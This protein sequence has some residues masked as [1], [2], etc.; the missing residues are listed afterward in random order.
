M[1]TGVT[2][3]IKIDEVRQEID[4]TY[5]NPGDDVEGDP[6]V[7][8]NGYSHRLIGDAFEFLCE[9]LLYR[10]CTEAVQPWQPSWGDDPKWRWTNGETPPI[11]VER[12][13][14]MRWEDYGDISS[15]SE[16]EEANDDLKPWERRRSAV[17]WTE[18][19]ELTKL[20]QQYVQTGMNTEG[21]V[22]A[23]L[24]DAGWKPSDSVQSWIDREAFEADVIEEMEALF[25]MLRDSEWTEGHTIFT[26]PTFGGHQ[27]ILPGEGDFIVDDLLV[28]I[29]TTQ[30]GTFT[31]AFWRQLLMYYVLVDVQRILKDVDGRT[32]G[33]EAFT[34]KYPEIN[35]VGIYYARFG[36]LKTINIEEVIDEV[37]R[38]EEFRAWIVD[39]AIEENSHAQ[40]DYSAIRAALTDAH[41]FQKQRT[42]FDDY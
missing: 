25:R 3:F 40:H 20:A 18:D 42:L 38:Y 41:D 12:F 5:P 2:K 21:V 4:S 35:R 29:K 37:G 9:L 34:G 32:Y 30:D 27:H 10:R 28:D 33:R 8:N 36:E 11:W 31:N 13:D 7:E 1:T 14:G 24:V 39:R 17:K 23:A 15:L 6:A 16:W 22:R 26:S 19:E